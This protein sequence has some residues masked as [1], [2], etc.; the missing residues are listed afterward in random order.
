VD[1][2]EN[3]VGRASYLPM[4]PLRDFRDARDLMELARE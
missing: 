4:K 2:V 3:R 1:L